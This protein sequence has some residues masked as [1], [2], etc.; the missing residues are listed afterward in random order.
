MKHVDL[1]VA[2][3]LLAPFVAV[4]AVL[5]AVLW[6]V[7]HAWH[8]SRVVVRDLTL[9]AAVRIARD[10]MAQDEAVRRSLAGAAWVE[11]VRAEDIDTEH[12]A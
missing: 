5:Y 10:E 9:F 7:A 2:A 11:P 8:R 6:G 1:L 12:G 3:V 4:G